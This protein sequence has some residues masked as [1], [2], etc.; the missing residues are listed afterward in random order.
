MHEPV[1]MVADYVTRIGEAP[2]VVWRGNGEV[3]VGSREPGRMGLHGMVF[4]LATEARDLAAVLA[5]YVNRMGATM[6][7]DVKAELRQ[8]L[9]RYEGTDAPV[10]ETARR[11]LERIEELERIVRESGVAS[12]AA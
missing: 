1:G 4:N 8:V 10:R 5:Y 2:Q 12:P 7:D 6:A 3:F 9:Y 11:A